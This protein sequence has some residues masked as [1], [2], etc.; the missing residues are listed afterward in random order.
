[1]FSV[2]ANPNL[3]FC[4]LAWAPFCLVA[5]TMCKRGSHTMVFIFLM[6]HIGSHWVYWTKVRGFVRTSHNMSWSRW[7][8][9][10]FEKR[11]LVRWKVRWCSGLVD[12]GQVGSSLMVS[13]EVNS[14]MTRVYGVGGHWQQA[15]MQVGTNTHMDPHS[16]LLD[17]LDVHQMERKAWHGLN[18]SLMSSP[19]TK[20]HNVYICDKENVAM[21]C[22][23]LG[24]K[25]GYLTI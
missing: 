3:S 7:S 2:N 20:I 14:C 9:W 8:V 19:C 5:T 21:R 16:Y 25:H 6:P 12:G 4:C 10:D 23:G 22:R 1:M 11:T 13:K 18:G 17:F 15:C 24:F